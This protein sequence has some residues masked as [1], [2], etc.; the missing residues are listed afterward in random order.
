MWYS[1]WEVVSKIVYLGVVKYL[2]GFWGKFVNSFGC[3]EEWSNYKEYDCGKY[4]C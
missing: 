2:F 1:Y 3:C 4:V